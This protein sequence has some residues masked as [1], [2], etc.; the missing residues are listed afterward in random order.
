MSHITGH[1]CAELINSLDIEIL[2]SGRQKAGIEWQ[3]SRSLPPNYSKLYFVLGGD[4]YIETASGRTRLERGQVYLIPTDLIYSNG[5]ESGIDFLYFNIRL[6]DRSGRDYLAACPGILSCE[7]SP[8]EI[9]LLSARYLS[10]KSSDHLVVKATILATLARLLEPLEG[11]RL[12]G[13]RYSAPVSRALDY[14]NSHLT[15]HL[16]LNEICAEI[17]TARSTLNKY[18][19]A[20]VGIPIGT[21]IDREIMTRAEQLLIDTD[22]SVAQI[23]E[24]FGFCDQFYFAR[25]F[26]EKFGETPHKYRKARTL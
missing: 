6:T 16:T 15:V 2:I 9:E 13:A 12:G 11:M 5:C 21:Y 17:Y 4:A 26:K 3:K 7:L 19:T 1:A 10:A 25:R 23:S 8:D 14:I 24:R 20:E 22:L 18:F